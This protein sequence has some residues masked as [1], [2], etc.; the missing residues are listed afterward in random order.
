[1]WWHHL[2][3]H[4]V[5]SCLVKESLMI[6]S[7]SCRTSFWQLF[8]SKVS[9]KSK[10]IGLIHYSSNSK[11]WLYSKFYTR[12]TYNWVFRNY[13][14]LKLWCL[15]LAHGFIKMILLLYCC[16]FKWSIEMLDFKFSQWFPICPPTLC[17]DSNRLI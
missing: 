2:W 4:V 7:Y 8:F 6:L 12:L 10:V 1:M 11:L 15:N 17:F 9:N 5:F 16:I 14:H 13:T 3:H